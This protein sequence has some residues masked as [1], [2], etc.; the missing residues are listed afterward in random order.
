MKIRTDFAGKYALVDV[1]AA[2]Q[3]IQ[4]FLDRLFIGLANHI[5][6]CSNSVCGVKI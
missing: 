6:N 4:T 2:I 5:D 3:L 1:K